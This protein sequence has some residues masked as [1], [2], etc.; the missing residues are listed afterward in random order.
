[1]DILSHQP[2]HVAVV[3]VVLAL[4]HYHHHIPLPRLLRTVWHTAHARLLYLFYHGPLVR[5][6]CRG[7][8]RLLRLRARILRARLL[9]AFTHAKRRRAFT[10]T[11]VVTYIVLP[12]FWRLIIACCF[13]PSHVLVHTIM[14]FCGGAAAALHPQR[15]G[16]SKHFLPTTRY[17]AW[18]LLTDGSLDGTL[19]ALFTNLVLPMLCMPF[20]SILPLYILLH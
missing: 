17:A 1:M 11:T 7:C 19:A 4:P 14:H 9:R 10:I 15:D 16:I 8:W 18:Q 13:V 6:Y 5:H 3:F 2:F 20:C 12:P